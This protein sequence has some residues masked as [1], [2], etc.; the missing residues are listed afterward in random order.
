MKFYPLLRFL[1]MEV[2]E[3][4][5]ISIVATGDSLITMKQS[6]HSEPRFLEL[7]DLIRGADVAFTNLEMLLH[8]YESDA[9]PAAECGGTYTRADPVMIE[10]LKWMGFDLVSTANNHSLDYMY[11]GLF[12]TLEHLDAAGVPHAGTG[13]NLA[14]AR[15][16]AYLETSRG[17]VALIAAASTFASFGRAGA[18][19][20]DMH[21]RPGLNPLRYETWYVVR[22]ET[23]EALKRVAEEMGL[24]E[25]VQPEDAYYFLRKKFVVG[26]DV[27]VHTK[28]HKGDMEGNL[29]AVRDAA[30]QADWVL[31][32]LHAHEGRMGDPE[33]PAEFIEEFAR[34]CIDAGAHAVIGHGHHAMRGIEIRDGRPIFYSLGDFIFQNE[35]VAKM[36]ADFYERYKLDPY[37]GTPADAY[38]ARQKAP[39]RPGYPAHKWFT[40][41]EKYWISVVPSMTFEGDRLTE[42]KL[43]PI[44]LGQAKPRSQR[45]RPMLA[46][47]ELAERILETMRELSRPY[48]TEITVEDGVGVV[49]L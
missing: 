33:R 47:P 18:A 4:K 26:E 25:V 27:G 29:E 17:R 30:R 2:L 6:V 42:L 23:L 5:R 45:G 31:F 49:K 39:P 19:R 7:A 37:S 20:R 11:G 24:P 35:T 41:E 44:D 9:Y 10:E 1:Y 12:K 3:L 21:G 16:P 43:H 46:E 38:D 14:E 40:E 15:Q 8:D 48:G 32:S 22:E 13:R 28:P 34:A 36:P